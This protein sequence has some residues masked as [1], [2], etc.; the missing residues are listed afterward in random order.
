MLHSNLGKVVTTTKLYDFSGIQT[1][2]EVALRSRVLH[3]S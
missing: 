2:F 1:N 3:E